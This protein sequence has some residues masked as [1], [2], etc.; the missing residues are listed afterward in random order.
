MTWV[1]LVVLGG[2]LGVSVRQSSRR[3][4][5]RQIPRR[6]VEVV[7]ECFRGTLALLPSQGERCLIVGLVPQQ[8]YRGGFDS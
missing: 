4:V 3:A 6:T 8:N 7:A 5:A 2:V 1:V